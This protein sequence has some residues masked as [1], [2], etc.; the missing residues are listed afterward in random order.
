MIDVN[1][2]NQYLCNLREYKEN[3]FTIFRNVIDPDLLAEAREHFLWLRKRFPEFRPEHLHHPLMRDDAFSVRLVTDERL[4]DIAELILGSDLAC[5]TAHYIC[6][7]PLDGH[8]VLWHQD[9]AYWNLSP[10]EATSLW[11]AIDESTTENGCLRVIPGSHKLGLQKLVLR[12]DTPNLLMTSM[13]DKHVDVHNAVDIELQPGDVSVHHPNIIHGSEAN[14]SSKRRCGLD[15]AY[16][17]TSTTIANEALYLNPILVRGASVTG[18]NKYRAWP[19][20]NANTSIPFNGWETWTRK[21]Q[22]INARHPEFVPARHDDEPVQEM[23]RRMLARIE[24]GTM[25]EPRPEP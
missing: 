22:D 14:R 1:K 12:R 21:S 13:E 11:L 10:M 9:G 17:N 20:F 5:F 2:R 15:M 18:V 24:S 8:A 6:K 4:L 23:V 3:G 7:P 16:I 25:K 19:S